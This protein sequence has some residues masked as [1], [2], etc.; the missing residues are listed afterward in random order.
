MT[1]E[2]IQFLPDAPGIYLFYNHERGLIYVGKATSLKNRVKSYFVLRHGSGQV[3]RP[4]EQMIHEVADI[5]W[6][7]TDSALE[8]V[9]LESIT[10][11]K[12]QPKY[13]VL[14]K[15]NKSW[16]YIVITKDEYPG[17][18]TMRQYE[19]EQMTPVEIK[20]RYRHI[21][22][23][24]PGLNRRATMK[25]LARLFHISFCEASP[26]SA[27][28]GKGKQPRPCLYYEMGQ[29]FG[30]CIRA[31]SGADYKERVIRPLVTLLRGQ[32]KKLLRL[33][34][35]RMEAESRAHHFEEAARLRDQLVSLRRIHDIAILNESFVKDP[36]LGPT[37]LAGRARLAAE[38]VGRVTPLLLPPTRGESDTRQ[39]PRSSL[40]LVRVEG[41]DI[42]NLG[43]TGQ[44]GSMVVFVHGEPD[45]RQYRK[46]RIRDVAGQ[47]DVDCLA[48]VIERRLNH[49]DWP[50]P[51]V[52]LVD[53][54]KPQLNRVKQILEKRKVRIPVIGIAKGPERKRND[55][56]LGSTEPEF[57]RWADSHREM[58]IRVRDEA[59]RF[60][61]QY[62]RRTRRIL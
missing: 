18:E 17:V 13:N 30:V 52:F 7:E 5:R 21:F 26:A 43:P 42:S 49:D 34:E 10:I 8:A 44:V 15:D 61:V 33:L 35:A 1:K 22:G 32:K 46:F 3:I 11:K 56:F 28:R 60:A 41:Y 53:G 6:K 14:G 57:I 2:E 51:A 59:H 39:A 58:L 23:P 54:G 24:Y 9:I 29:C 55:F 50:L 4:I 12:Y 45:T 37:A 27:F 16:N 48:E 31:L 62:Q 20:K 38:E 36:T 47:S 40:E 25:L 19:L